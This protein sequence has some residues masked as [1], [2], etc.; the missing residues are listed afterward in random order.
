MDQYKSTDLTAEARPRVAELRISFP[1]GAAPGVTTVLEEELTLSDG[2]VFY[3]GIPAI[4]S[5]VAADDV[6]YELHHETRAPTGNKMAM[7]EFLNWAAS[8]GITQHARRV[9]SKAVAAMLPVKD[10]SIPSKPMPAEAT[11]AIR[12]GGTD[13]FR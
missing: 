3:N 11:E 7:A 13:V 6:I 1:H 10:P 5:A 9:D 12:S 4:G 8:F 2:R